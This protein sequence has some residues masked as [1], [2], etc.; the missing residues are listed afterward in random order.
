MANRQILPGMKKRFLL[1]AALA[2]LT[3]CAA[4][5]EVKIGVVNDGTRRFLEEV[6]YTADTA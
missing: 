5:Q 1:L 6:D 3:V 4:A 2:A